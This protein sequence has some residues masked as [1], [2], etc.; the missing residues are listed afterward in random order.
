[1]HGVNGGNSTLGTISATG[2]YSPPSALPSPNTVTVTA[3]SVVDPSKSASTTITLVPSISGAAVKGPLMNATVTVYL[4]NA[5]DGSNGAVL[6]SGTTD[7]NGNFF[8][9]LNSVPTGPV[10]VVI[11]GGTYISEFDGTTITSTSTIAAV[12]DD[13]TGSVTG[14]SVTPITE[15]V[16]SLILHNLVGGATSFTDAHAAAEATFASFFGLSGGAILEHIFPKFAKS[17]IASDP[18]GFKVGLAI[19]SFALEGHNLVPAS[20]DDFLAAVSLDIQDGVFDGKGPD[21]KNIPLGGGFLSTTAATTDFLTALNNYILIGF[22]VTNAGITPSDVSGDVGSISGGVSSSSLTPPAVG[23]T[24]GSSGAISSLSFGGKQYVFVAAR[25]KGVVVI[26]VTDPSHPVSKS[27]PFLYTNTFGDYDVGGVIAVV[28][29]A[30]HPQVFVFAYGRKHVA[31]VNAQV[32]AT[33]TP[34]TDDALLVD[35]ETDL[36]LAATSP[37]FFSGGDAFIAGGIPDA[38]RKGVWL[39][40]ADGYYFFDLTTNTLGTL[41]PVESG[42]FLAENI[43]GDISHNVLLAGNYQ[44]VQLI[45]LLNAKSYQMDSSFFTS[46]VA[47]SLNPW[48]DFID[49]DS[50]DSNLQVSV[51]TS[52]DT[53]TAGFVNLATVVKTDSSDPTLPNTFVPANLNGYVGIALVS[54]SYGGPYVS[55]SGSAVDS[56]THL[57]L[58]MAGYSTSLAVG[59]LQDPAAVPPDGTWS[60]LT[61][62]SFM[63]LT[64]SPALSGYCYA[65][66]PHAAGAVF[67]ISASKS[68]GYLLDG[69]NFNVLQIDMGGFLAL[70]RVGT[71]GD[72]AHEP[73]GDP[74]AA[75]AILV[76]P[77]DTPGP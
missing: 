38:G 62:W 57:V 47:P 8:I 66:D 41:Y 36:P 16:S 42:Q 70:P 32:L 43:G 13:A 39:A 34:G 63:N 75:G 77:P 5:A 2:L 69:C 9:A 3:A 25:S 73:A 4:V 46:T 23:L 44:G 72:P 17:D 74:V 28:G 45:D 58:F 48:G 55:F 50:V 11:S 54:N 20:P 31:L 12:I 51:F 15:L 26:D 40:T 53:Y 59:Q 60:G 14:L 76:I 30:T 6:G 19:G 37:V 24:Q 18:D 67:N 65:R 49:A 35:F 21:G 64:T 52:E 1:V 7:S 61:D 27:W 71:T 33:G 29:T 22:A 68:Y 56:T 10:R